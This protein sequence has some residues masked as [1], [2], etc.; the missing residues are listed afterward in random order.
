MPFLIVFHLYRCGQCTVPT[1]S[2]SS[3]KSLDWVKI[4]AF[5]QDKYE[6]T[7]I[8]D[9]CHGKRKNITGKGENA[10]TNIFSFSRNVFKKLLFSWCLSP[11]CQ[12][13]THT[14]NET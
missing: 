2:W 6:F 4:K 8:R 3:L 7:K 5:A 11:F 9:F 14:Y 12:C 13:M 1:L 10:E